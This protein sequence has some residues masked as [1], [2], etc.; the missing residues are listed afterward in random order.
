[1]GLDSVQF[2]EGRL[3]DFIDPDH[4][5]IRIDRQLDFSKLVAPLESRYCRDHGRPAVHPEVMVRALLICSLYNIAPFRRLCS[6]ISEN[7]AFRWSCFLTIDDPVFDQPSISY[8]IERIGRDG[9]TETFHGLNQELLRLGLLSPELYA[10]G[11]RVKAS[12]S[13]HHL[14]PSGLAVEEFKEQAVEE[15]GLFI[16]RDSEPEGNGVEQKRAGYFQDSKGRLKLSPVD[17]DA[18]WGQKGHTKLSFLSYLENV[19]SDIN[20]FIMARKVNHSSE[21]E[22]KVVPQLLEQLPVAPVSLAADTA[23]NAGRL[24]Q[25]PDERGIMA[26]I[27]IH[28]NQESNM[29]AK[30]GFAYCGDHLVCPEGKQLR[31]SRPCPWSGPGGDGT[32]SP[33]NPPA[34]RSPASAGSTP[35]AGHRPVPGSTLALSQRQRRSTPPRYSKALTWHWMKAAVS[36]R[37]TNST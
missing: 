32:A 4:L 23:Y 29:V 33:R 11:S 27:P 10:D 1:M 25:L 37:R 26:H 5:L 17:T 19:I 9:F 24:R 6:A 31:R 3:R 36:A 12:V 22:W 28:P 34:W 15:N 30:G 35:A 13:C 2:T 16:V 20:G 18:P 8:F 21:G 14:S 7:I